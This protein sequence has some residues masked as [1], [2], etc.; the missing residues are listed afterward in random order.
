MTPA[1]K[2]IEGIAE[3]TDFTALAAKFG[4]TPV[5][6]GTY[7]T[8][9]FSDKSSAVQFHRSVSRLPGDEYPSEVKYDFSGGWTVYIVGFKYGR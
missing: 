5:A 6:G 3:G 9:I 7:P 8:F 1:Q 4:G 2:L